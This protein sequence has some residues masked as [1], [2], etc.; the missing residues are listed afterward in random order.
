MDPEQK[1][2][3][4]MV[5]WISRRYSE[6]I[7]NVPKDKKVLFFDLIVKEAYIGWGQSLGFKSVGDV[8]KFY[9]QCKQQLKQK[10]VPVSQKKE[11]RTLN[12]QLA[13]F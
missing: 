2:E 10:K 9:S 12:T 8:K 3:Q 5:E 1:A 11:V 13:F 7:K 6:N 4:V